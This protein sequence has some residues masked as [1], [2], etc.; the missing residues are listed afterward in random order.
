[1]KTDE[2]TAEEP[3]SLEALECI[4]LCD[5]RQAATID[6]EPVIGLSRVLRA[7]DELLES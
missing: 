5:I 1:M 6:D 4:G 7:V 3:I 2:R